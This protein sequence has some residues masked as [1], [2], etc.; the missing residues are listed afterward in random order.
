MTV[1]Q[2]GT[3]GAYSPNCLLFRGTEGNQPTIIAQLF[4]LLKIIKAFSIH[5]QYVKVPLF[6]KTVHQYFM[7][8][9]I[10]VLLQKQMEPYSTHVL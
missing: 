3:G 9:I 4:L 5:N 7:V 6:Y 2:N 10:Y 1:M 8:L